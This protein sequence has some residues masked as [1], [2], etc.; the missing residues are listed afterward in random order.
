MGMG[1]VKN[2]ITE[3]FGN[4]VSPGDFMLGNP[5]KTKISDVEYIML[6]PYGTKFLPYRTNKYY[7]CA[8][9]DNLLHYYDTLDYFEF[10][11]NNLAYG[12]TRSN[13]YYKLECLDNDERVI[14][15]SYKV[16]YD[17]RMEAIEYYNENKNYLPAGSIVSDRN[18]YKPKIYLGHYE[19]VLMAMDLEHIYNLKDKEY[20][21]RLC[22][23]KDL[24][25]VMSKTDKR[26][27]Y[28]LRYIYLN[29]YFYLK[30]NNTFYLPEL[31]KDNDIT[32]V[33][34]YMK[35]SYNTFLYH[36]K[37]PKSMYYCGYLDVSG[38][39][40]SL[41]LENTYLY[42]DE[43]FDLVQGYN[44]SDS[45]ENNNKPVC[46]TFEEVKNICNANN[47]LVCFNESL[48]YFFIV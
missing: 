12:N 8:D 36:N 39:Y 34:N 7:V 21:K 4:E 25:D 47:I 3:I 2:K 29:P 24:V 35:S 17:K 45:R 46:Y 31:I 1:K 33:I 9:N 5:N 42:L 48:S 44:Y 28:I 15:N 41:D 16:N 38:I 13:N 40:N 20:I 26:N 11:E 37:I 19:R 32:K 22:K 6:T 27:I 10:I 23:N 43:T 30:L 14:Y 18:E